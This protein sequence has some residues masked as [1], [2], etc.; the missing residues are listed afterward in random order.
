MTGQNITE[1]GK[2][3]HNYGCGHLVSK[4]PDVHVTVMFGKTHW[5]TASG[6]RSTQTF[7]LK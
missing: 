5:V 2:K 1:T 7:H 3:F 4:P 6:G